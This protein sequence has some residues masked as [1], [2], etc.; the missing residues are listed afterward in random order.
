MEIP[1]IDDYL[2]PRFRSKNKKRNDQNFLP[3]M[4]ICFVHNLEKEMDEKN[5]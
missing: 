2:E 1:T 4:I 3:T 5:V